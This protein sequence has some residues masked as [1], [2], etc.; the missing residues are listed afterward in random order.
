MYTNTCFPSVCRFVYLLVDLSISLSIIFYICLP[1]C[2]LDSITNCKI[3]SS[4]SQSHKHV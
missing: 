4:L 1:V 3:S 2:L